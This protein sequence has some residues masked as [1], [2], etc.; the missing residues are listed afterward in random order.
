MSLR[1]NRQAGNPDSLIEIDPD[2]ALLAGRGGQLLGQLPSS[3]HLRSAPC[4]AEG[5]HDRIKQLH[6]KAGELSFR[7]TVAQRGKGDDQPV[8]R[9]ARYRQYIVDP[10]GGR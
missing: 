8:T 3:S 4:P 2:P 1:E 9:Y 5:R 6:Q 7:M 10:P